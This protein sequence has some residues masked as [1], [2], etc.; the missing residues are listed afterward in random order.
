MERYAYVT[1]TDLECEWNDADEF[2][3]VEHC[4]CENEVHIHCQD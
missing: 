2:S 3:E 1:R 4:K